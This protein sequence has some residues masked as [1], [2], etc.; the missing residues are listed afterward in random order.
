VDVDVNG[1]TLGSLSIPRRAPVGSPVVFSVSAIDAQ[2]S[3]VPPPVWNFGDAADRG[4]TIV[5]TF[6]TPGTYAVIVTAEDALGNVTSSIPATIEITPRVGTAQLAQIKQMR[7]KALKKA[8]GRVRTVVTVDEPARVTLQV[9]TKGK[10]YH[11]V[12]RDLPSG[13]TAIVLTL[14]KAIRKV[15]ALS[16]VLT[17]RDSVLTATRTLKIVR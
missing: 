8:R 17:V 13:T 4:S 15:G 11:K 14:P 2:G 1:P 16:V 7:L 3:A 12:S 9:R 6:G 5:R 10:T